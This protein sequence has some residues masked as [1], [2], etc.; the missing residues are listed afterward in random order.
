MTGDVR[1]LPPGLE[2][3]A[4][5]SCQEAPANVRKHAGDGAFASVALAYARGS[6]FLAVRD[7]GC[8]FDPGVP[9]EGYG[10]PG[11]RARAAEFRGTAEVASGP[12]DGTTVTVLLPIPLAERSAP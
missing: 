8:G 10:L 3:V 1:P 5:R 7:T 2:V 6:L 11:L 4:L 12:G 9:H